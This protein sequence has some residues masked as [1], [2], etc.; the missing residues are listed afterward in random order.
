MKINKFLI[1]CFTI[2]IFFKQEVF[3]GNNEIIND[4]NKV[5]NVY[6][7]QIVDHPALNITAKGIIDELEKQGYKNN[8]NLNLK[9]E[10]AQGSASLSSQIASKFINQKPD[11]VVGIGT[12]SAQSFL[13]YANE[14]KVNLVFSSITDPIGAGLAENPE[15]ITGVSNFVDLEPQLELFKKIQP[16]LK[17][18]GVI[19]NP[20]ELNSISLN[21]KLEEVC[22][23]FGIKLVLQSASKTSDVPQATTK[24]INKV[25]AI[26]ITNDNTALSALQNI[27]NIANKEQKPV[28]V[29]DTDSIELGALAALGPNQYKI[30]IQTGEIISKILN[31]EKISNIK[32]QFP[33]KTELYLNEKAAKTLDIKI[34]DEIIQNASKIIKE[35]NDK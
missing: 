9:I 3:G 7:N 26:F 28:Y 1:N 29:S 13:K 18:L 31:G 17:T 25:D 19:Y 23:K 24:L 2:G 30:G 5:K 12:V 14:N 4:N 6:I 20:G 10:S 21:K 35:E 27:I 15:N 11:V 22:P 34:P 33:S 8:E 32:I 16:N